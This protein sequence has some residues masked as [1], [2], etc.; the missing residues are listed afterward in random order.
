M[1]VFKSCPVHWYHKTEVFSQ[2]LEYFIF[3]V[4]EISKIMAFSWVIKITIFLLKFPRCLHIFHHGEYLKNFRICCPW[5]GYRT[6]GFSC[7]N[8]V[9]RN[10]PKHFWVVEFH[11]SNIKYFQWVT[12]SNSFAM[13]QHSLHLLK[14]NSY[15]MQLP[16]W[17]YYIQEQYQRDNCH[18]WFIHWTYFVELNYESRKYYLSV[19]RWKLCWNS[20]KGKV[21][22]CLIFLIKKFECES[23]L[24]F[25]LQLQN[26]S[27]YLHVGT[28]DYFIII[29]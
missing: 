5:V 15:V 9:F 6:D 13:L 11:K 27:T 28:N 8:N 24:T 7:L 18:V 4:S 10:F 16:C 19:G 26:E 22:F 20:L 17:T 12:K 21:Q 29:I 14:P 2:I 1:F 25:R 23:N 3:K